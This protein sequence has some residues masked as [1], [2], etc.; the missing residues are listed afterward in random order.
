M[1]P[2]NPV[3]PFIDTPRVDVIK[4]V[5]SLKYMRLCKGTHSGHANQG[6]FYMVKLKINGSSD[7][8]LILESFNFT[9]K[10]LDTYGFDSLNILKLPGYRQHP[11]SYCDISIRIFD[12]QMLIEIPCRND[13]FATHKDF[14]NA[15]FVEIFLSHC[16]QLVIDPPLDSE[17]CI[18]PKYYPGLWKN[19]E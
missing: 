7:I 1:I 14:E 17:F 13:I 11:V 9:S 8:K 19:W 15:K 6:D 4:W 2:V 3:W 10:K 18:C 5:L 12:G 16:S